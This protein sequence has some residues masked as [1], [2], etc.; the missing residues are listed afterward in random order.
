MLKRLLPL[1][2]IVALVGSLA[3]C[4]SDGNGGTGSTSGSQSTG[5]LLNGWSDTTLAALAALGARAKAGTARD[6]AA[7]DKADAE[8]QSALKKIVIFPKQAKSTLGSDSGSATGKVL[9]ADAAAWKAWATLL[10]K[11]NLSD[12][13]SKK[14]GE[15]GGAAAAAHLAAYKAAGVE[16]PA[17]FQKQ[18]GGTSG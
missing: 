1:L 13:E 9:I 11:K 10:Q 12:Q 14:A 6:K 2:L 3:G 7:Y 5:E 18:A 15:L 16:V 4:G 8:L 17:D